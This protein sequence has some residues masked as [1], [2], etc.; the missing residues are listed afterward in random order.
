MHNHIL[1]AHTIQIHTDVSSLFSLCQPEVA[2]Y[3]TVTHVSC[4]SDC[5]IC[6]D[7][8]QNGSC[9]GQS[10]ITY[11]FF[12][13]GNATPISKHSIFFPT[14][15]GVSSGI[16]LRKVGGKSAPLATTR[17]HGRRGSG[18]RRVI[19]ARDGGTSGGDFQHQTPRALQLCKTTGVGEVD[20]AFQTL[21]TGK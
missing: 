17:L 16:I 5:L 3:C 11:W 10:C 14:Q 4:M 6:P 19:M 2:A 7:S 18:T 1:L 20:K 21:Q 8:T 9:C 12:S 15:H 13:K